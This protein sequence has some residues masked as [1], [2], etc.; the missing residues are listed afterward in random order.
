MK[1]LEILAAALAAV[2]WCGTAAAQDVA[3]APYQLEVRGG[4][5]T[6][7]ELGT[8][9][10]PAHRDRAGRAS[11]TLRFVRLRATRPDAGAPI[12]YL[13]GGPGGSGIESARGDRWAL[14]EMLRQHG[15]VILL[16]QRGAGLS[17]PAPAC[18]L[19]PS[20]PSDQPTTETS[21]NAALSTMVSGCAAEWRAAGV[22]LAAYN[23]AE[24]AAD[25]ADLARA[26][27]GR[28]R[29]VG[30]SYGTFLAFAVLRDHGA[31]I[32]RVV[33]AGTEGPDHTLKLPTQ[34]DDVLARLSARVAR[35]PVASQL[36]PDLQ[37][38]V[39]TVLA[40]LR[41][42]P[43]TAELRGSDGAVVPVVISAYDLQAVTTFLMATSA[44]AVRLP[45]L[46]AQMERGDF[47]GMAQMTMF[48]RRFL[49]QLPA[50]GLAMDGAS[51]VSPAR[52]RR[53]ARLARRSVFGNAVNAPS[54]DLGAAMSVAQLPARW[55][56]RLRSDVPAFFISGDLD[57]RTPPANAEEMRRGFRHSAH[58][59]LQGAGHDNDLFLSS[60]VI[61]ERIGAFLRGE[62]VRD[63]RVEVD[64][65]HFE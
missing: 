20:L 49:S 2:L 17:D 22:D 61:L 3:W 58:L 1:R 34:A 11:I 52:E 9:A 31:L 41:E 54:L 57:S 35:D 19:G 60:P 55:R 59:V 18:S 13:A 7:G 39:R 23:T 37:R 6:E 36:T 43:V 21:L 44:N 33:L 24:N 15:D 51:P 32:E 27:G 62:A 50:M 5:T 64:I 45:G 63:E 25:V 40:R 53:A 47:S 14:F 48:M 30:I 12:I 38:S 10:V 16:D 26:L 29:L 56:S 46:Y 8:L 28:V 42:A 65:L 4:P